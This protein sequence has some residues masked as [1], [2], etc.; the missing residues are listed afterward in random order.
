MMPPQRTTVALRDL[1]SALR[2]FMDGWP[3]AALALDAGSIVLSPANPRP[4]ELVSIRTE[5][6]NNGTADV[7]G[8]SIDVLA[9]DTREREPRVHRRF[10]RSIPAGESVSSNRR[11]RFRSDLAASWSPFCHS[12]RSRRSRH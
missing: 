7:F 6:R 1:P 5:L 10:V 4:G 12:P 3:R 9:F 11:R 2:S 8:L